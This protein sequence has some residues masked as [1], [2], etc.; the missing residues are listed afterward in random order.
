MRHSWRFGMRRPRPRAEKTI[1]GIIDGGVS[2]DAALIKLKTGRAYAKEKTGLIRHPTSVGGESFE[3]LIE[4]PAEYDPAKKW[5]AACPAAW[6]R[7]TSR[8]SQVVC[9]SRR[10][11]TGETADLHRAAGVRTKRLV[12]HE[13]GRQ[14][15]RPARHGEA[16]VHVDETQTYL[17][18]IS[19]GGTGTYFFALRGAGPVVG[20]PDAQRPAARARQPRC[21]HRRQPLSRQPRQL[22]ALHRERRSRSAVSGGN[23]HAD[24]RCD[25]R[26]GHLAGLPHHAERQARHALVA[27]GARLLRDVRALRIR[28]SRIRRSSRGKP[29]GRIDSTACA[30]SSST[31]LARGNPDCRARGC[32]RLQLSRARR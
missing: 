18:G 8:R 12:A 5:P 13:P 27:G 23:C 30:G 17:T 1:H 4:I 32:E 9:R 10:A 2:F 24:R 14:H 3:T 22:P 15:P 6:R 26:R 16:Q 7:R 28:A 25:A 20:M 29:I 11:S 31:S 19:D 21:A